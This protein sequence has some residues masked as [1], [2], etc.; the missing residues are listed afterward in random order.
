MFF[1]NASKSNLATY[2]RIIHY[3]KVRFILVIP[4]W[5][6]NPKS[7][8]VTYLIHRIRNKNCMIITKDSEKAFNKI[9][10]LNN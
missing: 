7:I 5:L 3:D 4:G 9:Q 8:N 6:N 2:K 1:K 10:M